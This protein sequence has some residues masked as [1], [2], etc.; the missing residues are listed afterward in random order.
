MLVAAYAP[1]VWVG[2]SDLATLGVFASEWRF[3]PLLFRLTEAWLPASLARPGTMGVI[4][5]GACLCA[6]WAYRAK[7]DDASPLAAAL[8]WLLLWAPVVN[9]WYWLWVLP[10]ALVSSLA[11]V[12]AAVLAASLIAPLSYL[13]VT[14]PGVAT[15][16]LPASVAVLQIGV[17]SAAALW[18]TLRARGTSARAAAGFPS[19]G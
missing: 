8:L 11:A 15:F 13:H 6:H 16:A 9:P 5:L 17:I 18:V 19:A 14:Q 4:A 10:L 3:N 7:Q 2:G 12:R 1:F